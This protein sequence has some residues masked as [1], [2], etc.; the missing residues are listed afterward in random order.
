MVMARAAALRSSLESQVDLV[1]LPFRTILEPLEL[2]EI[3]VPQRAT[4]DVD[5]W[6]DRIKA[7]GVA[8]DE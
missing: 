1:N 4:V 2:A 5:T 3:A 7:E 6:H 8:R